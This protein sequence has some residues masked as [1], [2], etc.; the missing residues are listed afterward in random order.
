M[1]PDPKGQKNLNHFFVVVV[2][3]QPMI[4]SPLI[5]RES[6]REV[7][8]RG[9]RGRGRETHGL[10]TSRVS[11]GQAGD[12]TCNPG[13]YFDQEMI[14]RYIDQCYNHLTTLVRAQTCIG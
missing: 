11:P 3:P 2:N 13:I 10:V 7:E 4:F 1:G 9:E 5:L 6:G 8:E 12:K 14:L